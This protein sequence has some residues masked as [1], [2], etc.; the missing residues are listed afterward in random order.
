MDKLLVE[1]NFSYHPPMG[2]QV[3]RYEAIRSEF[4]KLAHYINDNCPDSRDKS[5]SFTHLED[6]MTRAFGSI[7]R[8]E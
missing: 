2:T 1:H 7:A 5:L 3:A 8:N 4:K 6:S